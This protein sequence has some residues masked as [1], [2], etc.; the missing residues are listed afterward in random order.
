[1]TENAPMYR[2]R[3][4]D[5]PAGKEVRKVEGDW[6]AIDRRS[7]AIKN[8]GEDM[9]TAART[10]QLL[11]DGTLGQGKSLDAIRD[12]AKEV[13]EDLA[14]AG[15]RYTPSGEALATYATALEAVQDETDTLVDNAE[16]AWDEVNRTS[17]ALLEV[18]KDQSVFDRVAAEQ[19]NQ[20]DGS[21]SD[22]ARPDSSA[23]QAA[24]DAAVSEWQGYWSQ[25]DAPFETWEDA[26]A[27]A[28]DS[29]EEVNEDGVEDG[30]WDNAMPFVEVLIHALM[31][32]GLIALVTAIMVA[33]PLAA[34]AAA[35]LIVA[36]IA[37][38]MLELSK[39]A[40][41]RGSG[42]DT[43]LAVL[44]V[45]PFGKLTNISR[46]GEEFPQ[47]LQAMD[48]KARHLFEIDP[49]PWAKTHGL[50][51]RTMLRTFSLFK[52]ERHGPTAMLDA[53]CGL[54]PG[55]MP[56]TL[57]DAVLATSQGWANTVVG[58]NAALKLSGGVD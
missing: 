2:R 23:E 22:A 47:A 26:Y 39:Y 40:A 54:K 43:A 10:L 30:F 9:T 53:L 41:D 29:L 12:Q 36:S 50:N 34:L 37:S 18:E 42:R 20:P 35:I 48:D 58:A 44:G 56:A 33:G 13:H 52:W 28:R 8:L 3:M 5:T 19:A 6:E 38:L 55:E 21:E 11:A 24:F 51:T 15:E 57:T 45:V 1:M 27:V 46:L 7:T 14:T 31:W 4:P 25:Y 16:S 49:G 32:V 17:W